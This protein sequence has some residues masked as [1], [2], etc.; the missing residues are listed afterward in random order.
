[1]F[2]KYV[3][4]AFREGRGQI[5]YS[6]SSPSLFLVIKNLARITAKAE[7]KATIMIIGLLI[8]FAIFFIKWSY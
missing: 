7:I 6:S 4:P 1:M 3:N 2:K 5:F 8:V